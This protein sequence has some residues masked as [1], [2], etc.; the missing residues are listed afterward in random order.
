M[1][2]VVLTTSYPTS[3]HPAAGAFVHAC[4]EAAR[5]R[6]VELDVVSPSSFR[7]FGV[8]LGSGIAQ[9]LRAAPWKAALVPPFLASYTLA[10]KHAARHADLV[11]AHWLPSA[12]AARATR[13]PYVLQVWGTDVE[14]VR[15][16]PR[17]VR[18]LVRS[19][20]AVIAASSYLAEQAALL[21]AERI[22]I[23]PAPVSIPDVVGEPDDPPHVLFA[24][25]LSEEKGILEFLDATVGLPRVIV[26]D[27]PLRNRVPESVGFVTPADLGR[28]YARAAVVCV[29]S[30]REGY[31]VVA[32]EAMAYGRPV[33]ATNV[34]GLADLAGPGVELCATGDLRVSVAAL[35][36][37]RSRREQIGKAGR[38]VAE[39]SFSQGAVG[40]ALARVYASVA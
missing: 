29:P 19:A 11:H 7:H 1:K 34:G 12:L 8:A 10:A 21:G 24:G 22:E 36:A 35:L 37:D 5:G 16:F 15:R 33:V 2:V 3:S 13:K 26:G 32:R 27:G 23:V 14:L 20:Q 38:A 30:R 40:D 6:G 9:N 25:R 17:V 31:G 39:Q 18:P 4:V 28:Y